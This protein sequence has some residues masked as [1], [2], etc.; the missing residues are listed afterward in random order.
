VELSGGDGDAGPTRAKLGHS[1]HGVLE[2]DSV[3]DHVPM[4]VDKETPR[5]FV[6]DG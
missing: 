2:G 5:A 4:E 1:F 3:E 6:N